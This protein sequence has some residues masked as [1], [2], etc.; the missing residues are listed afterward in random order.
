MT[1]MP[2]IDSSMIKAPAL[3]DRLVLSEASLAMLQLLAIPS[4][5]SDISLPATSKVATCEAIIS[6]P[7]EILSA[8]GFNPLDA[9]ASHALCTAHHLRE[10]ERAWEQDSQ[11]WAKKMACLLKVRIN[12]TY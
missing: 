1:F 5:V 4:L 7:E 10:L 2:A 8:G 11:Q 3:A 12:A 9:A 6:A